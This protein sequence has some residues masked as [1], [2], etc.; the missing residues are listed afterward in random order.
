MVTV[1]PGIP[2]PPALRKGY[3]RKSH[4]YYEKGRESVKALLKRGV[5]NHVHEVIENTHTRTGRA[6]L[7]TFI[8]GARNQAKRLGNTITIMQRKD[9]MNTNV[10]VCFKSDLEGDC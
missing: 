7:S 10:Y 1:T 9:G 2:S 3:F 6:K 8:G 4:G 5:G